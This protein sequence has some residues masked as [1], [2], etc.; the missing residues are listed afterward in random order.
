MNAS[1]YGECKRAY[2]PETNRFY[3]NPTRVE[4]ALF[5]LARLQEF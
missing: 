4:T 1:G 2:I 3:R 5:G